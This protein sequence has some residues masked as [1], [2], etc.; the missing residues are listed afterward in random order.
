[1][2]SQVVH[3]EGR[4]EGGRGLDPLEDGVEAG[5]LEFGGDQQ[6][7]VHG[8][9][10]DQHAQRSRHKVIVWHRLHF[11][12]LMDRRPVVLKSQISAAECGWMGGFRRGRNS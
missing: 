4:L 8:I 5:T 6:R 12:N 1:M 9:L 2:R 11:G 10:D 3:L 7:V